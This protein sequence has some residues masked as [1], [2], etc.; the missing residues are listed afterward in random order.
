VLAGLQKRDNFFTLIVGLAGTGNQTRSTCVAGSGVNRSAIHYDFTSKNLL[1][2]TVPAM[3]QND[4]DEVNG[5][6]QLLF[7][8]V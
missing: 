7:V 6:L 4:R 8:Q 5:F 1:A 3:I 2:S